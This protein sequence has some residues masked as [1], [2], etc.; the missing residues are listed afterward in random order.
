MSAEKVYEMLWD[1]KYCGTQ[2]LLGKTHR[3]C[4][5]CGAAQD[6]EARYFPS[7]DEK[8]AVQDH[9]FYG[10]DLI[11][12]SC[13]T[14][15]SA[16]SDYCQ[17]CGSSLENA[18]AAQLASDDQ[19]VMAGQ[20]FAAAGSGNVAQKRFEQ[21][22]QDA[23][24]TDKPKSN[25]KLIYIIL[26]VVLI[27]GVLLCGAL[28]WTKEADAYVA[29]HEWERVINIEQLAPMNTSAWCDA[30]PRDAYSVTQRREQRD[31]RR[32]PDGQECSTVRVDN[33]DGTYSER[34]Q[35]H[36]VYR[37][38]PVYDQ[39]C[40][41]TV[42]R[43][44]VD[45]AVTASGTALSDTPQWPQ[46]QLQRTGNCL[47]CEREG[48]RSEVYIVYL[49]TDDG[50]YSCEVSQ[51]DWEQMPI[52]SIWKFQIGVVTGQPDCASLQPAS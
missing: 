5:N 10:A 36:T 17:Q 27:G 42:D 16:N 44:G 37:E 49:K 2:K 51:A 45:R 26:A 34:Q 35:C 19:V 22:L 1:C 31:T 18:K 13:D 23:G 9:V 20:S 8:V 6:D 43:W 14:L 25:R 41:Y 47:G 38:E 46:V 32:V 24:I 33:G 12:P 4:P 11:C 21:K 39:R 48:D 52:E 40:Y 15:N 28:L 50:E 30:M 29:G 7:D 3:F